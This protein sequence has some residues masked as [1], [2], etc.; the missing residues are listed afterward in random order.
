VHLG[1]DD[2]TAKLNFSSAILLSLFDLL[3]GILPLQAIYFLLSLFGLGGLRLSVERKTTLKDLCKTSPIF[4]K[5][6]PS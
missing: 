5:I 4:S 2:Q 1:F 6:A 3:E